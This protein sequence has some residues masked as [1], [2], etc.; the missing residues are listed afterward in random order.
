MNH[1]E[2]DQEIMLKTAERYDP[3]E[4]TWHSL[5]D[6]PR[7]CFDLA[8]T[9]VGEVLYISG[10]ITE[11]PDDTIPIND[12]FQYTPGTDAWVAKAPMLHKRQ[13]HSMVAHGNKIYVF[14]GYTSSDDVN[15]EDCYSNE[16]YDVETDQWQ[17]L[18]QTPV[19][20]GHLQRSVAKLDGKVYLIGGSD[21]DRTL[22]TFDLE[23]EQFVEQEPCGL[24]YL[25]AMVLSVPL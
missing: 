23:T 25:K 16:V 21:I 11:D 9:C 7:G 10:G 4:N 20:F 17:E 8:A 2:T 13:G 24:H 1:T 12:L 5:P 14:G 19:E 6:L 3:E 22:H 18:A 15:M